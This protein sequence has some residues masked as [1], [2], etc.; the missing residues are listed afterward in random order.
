MDKKT[1]LKP[2]PFCG[3]PAGSGEYAKN[4]DGHTLWGVWCTG[5]PARIFGLGNENVWVKQ[6]NKR[7]E[8]TS[9][10]E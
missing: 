5:C 9:R 1:E 2:C 4:I 8:T 6:W 7:T 10:S 3:E